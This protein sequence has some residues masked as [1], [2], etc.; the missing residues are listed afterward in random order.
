MIVLK[1]GTSYLATPYW[2]QVCWVGAIEEARQFENLESFY[3]DSYEW[4]RKA[5]ALLTIEVVN[6]L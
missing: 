1:H 5:L 2:G 6:I 4:E 3:Q